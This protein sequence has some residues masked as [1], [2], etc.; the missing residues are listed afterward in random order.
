MLIACRRPPWY[1]AFFCVARLVSLDLSADGQTMNRD[2]N[3][4]KCSR[5][6]LSSTC[7]VWQGLALRSEMLATS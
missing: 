4:G 3:G 5:Q 1:D 7:K 2:K 6:I